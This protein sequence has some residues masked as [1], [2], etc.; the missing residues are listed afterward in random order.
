MSEEKM[1]S[2]NVAFALGIVCVLVIVGLGGGMAYY[3]SVHHHTDSD[4]DSFISWNTYLN[5]VVNLNNSGVWE[6]NRTVD[7][8]AGAYGS[9]TYS[10]NYAGYISVNV[11]SST[12]HDTYVEVIYSAYGVNYD[13][14]THTGFSSGIFVY[15]VLPT[16]SLE[17]RVGN[18]DTVGATEIVTITYYY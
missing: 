16:S 12:S 2:R 18:F 11:E 8:P 5:N 4:Y 1:V 6:S 9:F 13:N 3:V 15:P 7:E 14:R 10:P 17:V